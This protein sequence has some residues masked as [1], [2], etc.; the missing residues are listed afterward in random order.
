MIIKSVQTVKLATATLLALTLAACAGLGQPHPIVGEWDATI[1]TPMG[2]MNAGLVVNED[3]T[4]EMRSP[5]LGA[6][7][8]DNVT[9]E[10]DQVSFSTTVD[11]QGMM[12][13]LDFDGMV[14]GDSLEG[15]FNS[16]FGEI[17]MTASRR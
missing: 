13:T 9:V 7:A 4:G 8:L 16:D 12:L 17:G 14:E 2:A 11:A 3:M 5:E 6:T 10:G 1:S 15:R